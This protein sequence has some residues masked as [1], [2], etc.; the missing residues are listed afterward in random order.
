MQSAYQTFVNS[1]VRT[2]TAKLSEVEPKVWSVTPEDWSALPAGYGQVMLEQYKIYVEMA[3]RISARRALANTFFLTLNAAV[4][5]LFGVLWQYQPSGSAWWLIF[6]LIAL[7][8][9]CAAWYWILRSYRQ[10]NSAKY[11]VIGAIE[12]RLPISPYWAAE[13]NAL[14]EGKDPSR[15]LPLTHAE[16]WIPLLFGITYLA[17]FI[18]ALL[19]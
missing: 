15:Y 4:F 19:A 14:G 7:V 2:S 16:Q 1:F 13:W 12:S 18:A 17:A 9:Q 5:T 3:D 8:G 11:T 6:P 10:L